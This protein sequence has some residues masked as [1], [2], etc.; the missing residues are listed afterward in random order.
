MNLL[1]TYL[2]GRN[3]C[4]LGD[5]YSVNHPISVAI[6]DRALRIG[7]IWF[8]IDVPS[9]CFRCTLHA[10]KIPQENVACTIWVRSDS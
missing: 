9:R 10:V 4:N 8:P 3:G 7:E 1:S 6:P 2:I 5:E